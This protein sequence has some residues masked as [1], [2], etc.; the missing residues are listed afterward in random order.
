MENE[1]IVIFKDKKSRQI[2]TY[3]NLDGHGAKVSIEDFIGLLCEYYGS[4]ASTFKRKTHLQRLLDASELV[5]KE[6]KL[7]T[8]EVAAINM[9]PAIKP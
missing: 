8:R 4:P 7:K 5:V 1:M 6:M 3:V 9:E 2:Q